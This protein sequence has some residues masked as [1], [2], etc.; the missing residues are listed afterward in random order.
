MESQR[1]SNLAPAGP[2]GSDVCRRLKIMDEQDLE[3]NRP[4][5]AEQNRPEQHRGEFVQ[6]LTK[7][8]LGLLRY[9]TAL[10]GNTDAASNI[11]QETNLLLWQKADEFQPGTNFE[12][13]ATKVAY[14]QVKAYVRDRG[15]DRHVF[16]EELVTQLAESSEDAS[17]IDVT[18]RLLQRCLEVLRRADRELIAL[19]YGNGFSVRQMSS[20]LG[21]SPAAVKGALMRTRRALKA[22]VERRLSQER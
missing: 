22:C 9:I 14:W 10:V 21:K 20:H 18:V 19:R 17:D 15:R 11:L 3:P 1:S 5:F 12:A 8:Q 2:E 6:A 13:W 4:N 16:S 7:A